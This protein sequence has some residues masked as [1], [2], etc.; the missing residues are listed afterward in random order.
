MTLEDHVTLA[1]LLSP[2]LPI[3]VPA[4]AS[5]MLALLGWIAAKL[6]ASS[7]ATVA[8]VGKSIEAHL[9][10]DLQV[11]AH[12]A[13][14]LLLQQVQ[15]QAEKID[16]TLGSHQ[17]NQA[18]AYIN[19]AAADAVRRFNLNDAAMIE[20]VQAKIGVLTAPQSSTPPL[21]I[22]DVALTGG[23]VP[24]SIVVKR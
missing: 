16:L 4:V 12:N 15:G 3:I 23:D 6:N 10:D 18:I 13:A 7:N 1:T 14:G 22:S 24:G 21:V 2:W 19:S 9:R 11:A 17:A 8:G 5:A 20:K